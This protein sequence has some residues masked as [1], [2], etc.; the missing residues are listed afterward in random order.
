MGM[1]DVVL[2]SGFSRDCGKFA[3][4]EERATEII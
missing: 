1:L 4:A 2:V 3:D